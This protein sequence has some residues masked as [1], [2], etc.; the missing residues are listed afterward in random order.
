MMQPTQKAS[1]LIK[2]PLQKTMLVGALLACPIASAQIVRAPVLSVTQETFAT[3]TRPQVCW[4]SIITAHEK[5][6]RQEQNTPWLLKNWQPLLGAA[7]GGA[8]G[9]QFTGNY[10]PTSQ[11]WKWPTVAGGAV[12]GAVAGPGATAGAYGLGTLAHSLWPTSLAMTAGFTLVGGIVGKIVW[13]MIFP[14]NKNLQKPEQGQ[15]LA[16]QT[17]YLETTCTKPERVEYRQA[18]YLITYM[19][20]GKKQ[21]ARVKYYPGARVELSSTGRPVYEVMPQ[22]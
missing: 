16:N 6:V 22:P 4:Q 8:I 12:V 17:F 14:P 10:G 18:P 21:T 5:A 7:M 11:K 2:R 19:H 13:E 1:S 9:F 20:E 15:F 3:V